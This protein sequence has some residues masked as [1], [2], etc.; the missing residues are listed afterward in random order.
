MSNQYFEITIKLPDVKHCSD[1]P[2]SKR[3]VGGKCWCA[4]LWE[5]LVYDEKKKQT[6]RC[7]N[8]IELYS[9]KEIG[10]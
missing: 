4:N 9:L 8:C 10:E 6:L 7:K 2:Y 3:Y 5:H 1:C